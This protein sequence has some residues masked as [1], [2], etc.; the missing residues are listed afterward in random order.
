MLTSTLTAQEYNAQVI[1]L[2]DAV[3]ANAF[4]LYFD[5]EGVLISYW[6]PVNK[7]GSKEKVF[8]H[9]GHAHLKAIEANSFT[10]SVN[11]YG[12]TLATDWAIDDYNTWK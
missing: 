10:T 3:P 12:S 7:S 6:I 1:G 9:R 2:D 11:P 8:T 5:S 4:D